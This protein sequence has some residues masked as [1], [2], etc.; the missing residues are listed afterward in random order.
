MIKHAVWATF[1][2]SAA[3]GQTR[4]GI[5]ISL[6]EIGPDVVATGSGTANLAALTI[7]VPVFHGPD[8]VGSSAVVELAG[9]LQTRRLYTGQMGPT[10][11]GVGPQIAAN[12]GTGPIFGEFGAAGSL[13]VPDGYV[14]GDLLSGSA[15]WNNQT[16]SGLGLTPGTYTWNWGSGGTADFIQ[17][18]IGVP[19][20]G[21]MFLA[22]IGVGAFGF[23][24]RTRR[25]R[26]ASA[27]A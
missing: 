16:F 17:V 27:N 22:A 24:A 4:A 2:L 15:T 9:G 1:I 14:S 19:E 11:F 6:S 7:G 26:A 23:G 20:P 21:S 8:V 10:Q 18:T 12:S 13:I 3:V 5:I 25:R